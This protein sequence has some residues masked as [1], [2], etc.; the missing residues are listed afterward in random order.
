MQRFSIKNGS[1]GTQEIRKRKDQLAVL[2]VVEI[3]VVRGACTVQTYPNYLA[4]EWDSSLELSSF[5]SASA[6]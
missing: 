5:F 3:F 2:G 6:D 1:S 4:A